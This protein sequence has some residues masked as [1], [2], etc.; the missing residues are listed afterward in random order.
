MD[1]MLFTVLNALIDFVFFLDM[2][3]TF[4][5]TYIDSFGDEEGRPLYVAR[6]YLK[7]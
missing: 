2:I 6:N 5:T 7:G 4:R 3:V 1:S